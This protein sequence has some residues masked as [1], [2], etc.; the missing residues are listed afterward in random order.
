MWIMVGT[1]IALLTLLHLLYLL[2]V[3]SRK[4]ELMRELPITKSEGD[5]EKGASGRQQVASWKQPL[6]AIDTAFKITVFRWTVPYG[7]NYVL[8]LTELFFTLGYLAASL[9]WLLIHCAYACY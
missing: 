5:A 6:L 7:R 4:H 9:T 3:R 8:S 2:R 1:T